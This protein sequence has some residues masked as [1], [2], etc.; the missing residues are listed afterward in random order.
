MFIFPEF[1]TLIARGAQGPRWRPPGRRYE[2]NGEREM[3][4]R[5][6]QHA[7]ALQQESHMPGTVWPPHIG[8]RDPE[9]RFK[10]GP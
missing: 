10:D 1:P 2:P 3:A 6:R 4:R 8:D 9:V 5:R 7:A